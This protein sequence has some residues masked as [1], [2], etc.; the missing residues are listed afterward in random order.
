MKTI[1]ALPFDALSPLSAARFSVHRRTPQATG[2]RR[3]DRRRARRAHTGPRRKLD[4]SEPPPGLPPAVPG[5]VYALLSAQA[6][7]AILC[8]VASVKLSE[9][10]NRQSPV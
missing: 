5:F 4:S 1:H 8:G 6:L 10:D 2:V 9:K 3:P 7:A